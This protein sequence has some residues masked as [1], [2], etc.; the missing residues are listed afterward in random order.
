MWI[1]AVEFILNH[2]TLHQNVFDFIISAD[3]VQPYK[4]ISVT[5]I[6]VTKTDWLIL[7]VRE[8]K[9]PVKAFFDF[10]WKGSYSTFSFLNSSFHLRIDQPNVRAAGEYL[11]PSLQRRPVAGRPKY[12]SRK[13]WNDA[14]HVI[15]TGQTISQQ[16][17]DCDNYLLADWTVTNNKNE[18]AF[19]F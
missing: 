15:I 2:P 14:G 19:F 11:M 5:L 18:A 7:N 9:P 3:G 12:V 6:T 13:L 4:S 8:W 16:N 1:D 10:S 17:A